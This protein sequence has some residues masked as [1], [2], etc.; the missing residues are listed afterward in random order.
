M[1]PPSTERSASD[2]TERS[3]HILVKLAANWECVPTMLDSLLPYMRNLLPVIEQLEVPVVEKSI[4]ELFNQLV[5]TSYQQLNETTSVEAKHSIFLEFSKL[6]QAALELMRGKQSL[7]FT[8]LSTINRIM[9]VCIV[10]RN[11]DFGSAAPKADNDSSPF[12]EVGPEFTA[13]RGGHHVGSW[14]SAS[15]GR[16]QH[17]AKFQSHA[18]PHTGL[19]SRLISSDDSTTPA[20]FTSTPKGLSST[21]AGTGL[22]CAASSGIPSSS[23]SATS[24]GVSS[25]AASSSTSVTCSSTLNRISSLHKRR[26]SQPS[27]EHQQ[28][29]ANGAEEDDP[30][31]AGG[32]AVVRTPLEIL[33]SLDPSQIVSCLHNNITMH[34]RIIGTRHKCTPSVRHRH[35]THH[36]LQILSARVLT[37]MCHSAHVQHKLVT[38]G[39][40]KMLVEALDPNH[41]PAECYWNDVWTTLGPVEKYPSGPQ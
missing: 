9:D 11:Y 19:Y 34:R 39:H 24:P 10:Y 20:S 35:C 17:P 5:Q 28:H 7:H 26:A 25:P 37:L 14:R 2:E 41:D 6:L 23:C 4:N 21:L 38:R 27:H 40:L 33:L 12:S 3:L 32:G 22:S 8:A 13:G 29:P 31:R 15:V 30:A 36:C 16:D 1:L 18:H